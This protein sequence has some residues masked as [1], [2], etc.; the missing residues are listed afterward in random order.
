[1]KIRS[2]LSDFVKNFDLF[3]L[4]QFLRYRQDEDYTTASGGITSIVI[5]GVFI[6]FFASNAISTVNKTDIKW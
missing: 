5:V 2:C 6:I 1:M 3:S 4:T